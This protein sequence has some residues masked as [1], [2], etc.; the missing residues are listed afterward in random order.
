MKSKAPFDN[1]I[2]MVIY[3]CVNVLI[4]IFVKFIRKHHNLDAL[5][6]LTDKNT[7]N[8]AIALVFFKYDE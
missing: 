5:D 6:T 1:E 2:K 8:V 7:Q 3:Q 4:I